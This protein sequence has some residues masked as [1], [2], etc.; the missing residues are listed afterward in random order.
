MLGE[1]LDRDGALED[2]VG[3]PVDVRHP[4]RAEALADLVSLRERLRRH[5]PSP[6]GLAGLT[7]P[8][9]S[10]PSSTEGGGPSPSLPF[11]SASD[12]GDTG[13][14]PPPSPS[15]PSSISACF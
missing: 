6:A 14:G 13:G 5:Q 9:G 12:W 1:D 4:P 2:A 7:P 8:E 15:S 11:P 3:R 10:P